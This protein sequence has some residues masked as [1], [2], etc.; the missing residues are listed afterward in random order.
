MRPI[1]RFFVDAAVHETGWGGS[2]SLGTTTIG[3]ITVGGCSLY[4]WLSNLY[5]GHT[6]G[7][8]WRIRVGNIATLSTGTEWGGSDSRPRFRGIVFPT[9]D[10]LASG[11][12]FDYR[13]SQS[14]SCYAT[15][16]VDEGKGEY[17]DFYVPDTAVTMLT[18]AGGAKTVAYAKWGIYVTRAVKDLTAFQYSVSKATA[19]DF[20]FHGWAYVPPMVVP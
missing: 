16:L 2:T 7:A 3:S 15:E 8:N 14:E 12:F 17:A 1:K 4:R 13:A 5:I 11:P 9:A 10:T 19:E 18:P 20:S 6:G